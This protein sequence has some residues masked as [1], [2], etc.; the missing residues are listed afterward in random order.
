MREY[1]LLQLI[2]TNKLLLEFLLLH[3]L[4]FLKE[5]TGILSAQKLHCLMHKLAY[6][7]PEDSKIIVPKLLIH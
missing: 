5:E 6:L 3:V 7:C 4:P 1:F 2:D